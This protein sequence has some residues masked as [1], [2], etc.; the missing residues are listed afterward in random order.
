M[1]KLCQT[2]N[3][4][5]AT[6]IEEYVPATVPTKIVRTKYLRLIGPRK[7]KDKSTKTRVKEVLTDRAMVS[8]RLLF[9]ISDKL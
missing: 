3:N 6:K 8:L 7:Y 5:L 4:G 9:T 2:T 1:E